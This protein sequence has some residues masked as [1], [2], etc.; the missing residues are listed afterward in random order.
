MASLKQIQGE[1][2]I[3]VGTLAA[4]DQVATE[5]ANCDRVGLA[6]QANIVHDFLAG[7][8]PVLNI[9]IEVVAY[10]FVVG[11]II[12]RDLG[13]GQEAGDLLWKRHG[14]VTWRK[15]YLRRRMLLNLLKCAPYQ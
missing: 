13:E 7:I 2:K 11:K 3:Q 1:F 12:Q 15:L 10:L 8:D 6:I 9:C 14:N 5:L 4:R